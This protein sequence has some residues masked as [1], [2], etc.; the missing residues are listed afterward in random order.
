MNIVNFLATN[1]IT[2]TMSEARRILKQG[3]IKINGKKVND[4]YI[5]NVPL[6]DELVISVGKTR[7]YILNTEIK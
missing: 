5:I 4:E 6:K 2:K 1:G 7:Q 3:G